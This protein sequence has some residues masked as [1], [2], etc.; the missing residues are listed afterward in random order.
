MDYPWFLFPATEDLRDKFVQLLR[1]FSMRDSSKIRHFISTF[2]PCISLR[3]ILLI[4]LIYIYQFTSSN[5]QRRAHPYFSDKPI[6]W[7]LRLPIYG[8]C[9]QSRHPE[10]FLLVILLVEILFVKL[11]EG[12][13]LISTKFHLFWPLLLRI[14]DFVRHLFLFL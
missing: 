3:Y 7:R 8:D 12:L 5:I 4:K 11:S 1:S 6:F 14:Q 13:R 2:L 10:L 9:M